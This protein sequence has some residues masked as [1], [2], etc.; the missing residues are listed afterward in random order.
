MTSTF[1][2]AGAWGAG[3]GRPLTWAEQDNNT[4]DK[5][6]RLADLESLIS[7][8][9]G[10]AVGI[11]NIELSGTNVLIITMTDSSVYTFE[12][13]G[14][15]AWSPQGEWQASSVYHQY[16][17]IYAMGGAYLVNADHTSAT[18]FDPDEMLDTIPLYTLILPFAPIQGINITTT[19]FSPGLE[20]ANMYIRLTNAGGCTVTIDG[21]VAFPDWTELTFRDESTDTGAA[22]SFAVS[23]GASINDVNGHNNVSAGRGSVVT[24]KRVG[25][26]DAW[27]IMGRLEQTSA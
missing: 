17:V 8:T 20:H 26:T 19:T 23:G 5:E 4:Y 3:V 15:A 14:A 25:S 21:G 2:T 1:R 13:P 6:T 18:S 12:I 24:L 11:A 16:D 7:I 27:D 9:G 22:A 10:G